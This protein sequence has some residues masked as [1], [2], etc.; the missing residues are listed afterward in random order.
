M[1][2]F[3]KGLLFVPLSII[4]FYIL[5]A[6][7]FRDPKPNYTVKD[8]S[9]F[10]KIS[11]SEISTNHIEEGKFKSIVNLKHTN[12]RK[13]GKQFYGQAIH[14]KNNENIDQILIGI[15]N[16]SISR[17]EIWNN[18]KLVDVI[19]KGF[20]GKMTFGQK[21][22]LTVRFSEQSDANQPD[23]KYNVK[24][25]IRMQFYR[26]THFFGSIGNI[27]C[28]LSKYGDLSGEKEISVFAKSIESD[29]QPQINFTDL[30]VWKNYISAD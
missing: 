17:I 1:K 6:F 16:N 29:H 5:L 7:S 13:L 14:I 10:D 21:H 4:L 11:L 30:N 18:H 15:T 22:G 19:E 2:K 12:Y 28:D 9:N 8:L 23:A 26:R 20:S 27:N 24:N 25:S 3:I